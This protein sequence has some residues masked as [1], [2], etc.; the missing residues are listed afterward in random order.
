[1]TEVYSVVNAIVVHVNGPSS[2]PS[3]LGLRFA[4]ERESSLSN[5]LAHICQ[6]QKY[7]ILGR[8][9]LKP[10]HYSIV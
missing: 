2:Y 9:G 3:S 1:M 6:I 7:R 10:E 4:A 8:V 5:E